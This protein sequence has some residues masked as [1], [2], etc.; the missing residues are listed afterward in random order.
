MGALFDAIRAGDQAAI[1]EL[2]RLARELARRVCRGGGP[3]GA[4]DLDSQDVAREA[5]RKLLDVGIEQD[6]EIESEQGYVGGVVKAI[7]IRRSRGAR[8]RRSRAAAAT[9]P[10]LAIVRTLE[11]ISPEC[12]RLIA[13]VFFD[14]QSCADLANEAGL[15]E[16]SVR[17]KLSRYIRQARHDATR[18]ES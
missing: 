16:A 3:A 4:A 13:S 12:R 8:R 18:D 14:D 10:R 6:P 7:V 17:E 11:R 9:P 15:P 5:V 2:D 1:A